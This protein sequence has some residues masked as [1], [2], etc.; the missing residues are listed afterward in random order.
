MNKKIGFV[1]NSAI[2]NA[3]I[4]RIRSARVPALAALAAL[5]AACAPVREPPQEVATTS[6]TVSYNYNTDDGLVEANA[7]ARTYC[8]QYSGTPGLQGSITTNSDGTKTVTFECIKTAAGVAPPAAPTT[9]GYT[10]RSDREFVQSIQSADAYCAQSGQ[11]ASTHIVSNTDGSKT[12]TF[13]CV[14]R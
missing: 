12:V 2:R 7:K 14:P 11:T 10:F 8:A 9:S 13:Q 1:N 4:G 6:P 3:A 5:A